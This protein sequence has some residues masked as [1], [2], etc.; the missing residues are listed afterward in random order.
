[1]YFVPFISGE[2]CIFSHAKTLIKGDSVFIEFKG[3]L[4]EQFVFQ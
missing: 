3:A 1:V 4:A 2:K